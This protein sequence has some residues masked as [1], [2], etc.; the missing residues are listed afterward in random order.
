MA[1]ELISFRLSNN[2][3]DWLREQCKDGESL[4]LAAKR[5][6]LSLNSGVN[7][8]VDTVDISVNSVDTPNIKEELEQLQSNLDERLAEIEERLGKLKA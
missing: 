8:T 1:S 2:E 3:L 7:S 6:L 4:N 5:L